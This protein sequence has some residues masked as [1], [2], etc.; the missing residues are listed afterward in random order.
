MTCREFYFAPPSGGRSGSDIKGD[1]EG[2]VKLL[3]G[4]AV[5]KNGDQQHFVPY[6]S[7]AVIV[8]EGAR[9]KSGGWK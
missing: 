8:E 6:A 3:F 7:M 5:L 1:E 2:D 4:G 9:P